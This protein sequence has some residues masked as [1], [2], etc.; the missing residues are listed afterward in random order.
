MVS[1]FGFHSCW[2]VFSSLFHCLLRFVLQTT[3]RAFVFPRGIGE[4]TSPSSQKW[5]LVFVLER[6]FHGVQKSVFYTMW[7]EHFSSNTWKVLVHC[8]L[9]RVVS[10]KKSVVS[11]TF[12][13]IYMFCLFVFTNCFYVSVFITVLS[14]LCGF[15]V[16]FF[17]SFSVWDLA[18]FLDL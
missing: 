12:V 7:E 15:C 6:C 2:I 9:S 3:S 8:F 14:S 17:V 4:R 13:S 5:S 11:F 10:D 1:F 16:V 18:R